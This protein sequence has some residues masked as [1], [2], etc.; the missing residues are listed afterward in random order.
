MTQTGFIIPTP[1]RSHD[2]ITFAADGITEAS[3]T[4]PDALDISDYQSE[5]KTYD[6]QILNQN[7]NRNKV[8][9]LVWQQCTES[10]QAKIK[11]HRNYLTIERDLNGIDLLKVIELICFNIEDKKYIPQKVHEVKS[12]F[13]AL[14]FESNSGCDSALVFGSYY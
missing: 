12:A 3:R 8:F 14:V 6:Y 4:P 5:K 7:E 9:S 10:M 11:S 2:I 13:Y 1:L